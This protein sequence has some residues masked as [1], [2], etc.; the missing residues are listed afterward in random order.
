MKINTTSKDG[1]TQVEISVDENERMIE[2][3]REKGKW[4]R[5]RIIPQGH[6]YDSYRVWLKENEVEDIDE[7]VAKIRKLVEESPQRTVLETFL[8]QCK[9]DD[10]I[11]M[12]G[13]WEFLGY[14]KEDQEKILSAW[15]EVLRPGDG[16]LRTSLYQDDHDYTNIETEPVLVR[17]TVLR[18]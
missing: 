13:L 2:S 18:K 16:I 12:D 8:A 10:Y 7:Q 1:E 11:I 9:V 3:D 14:L 4:L 5:L 17:I 6:W 15:T